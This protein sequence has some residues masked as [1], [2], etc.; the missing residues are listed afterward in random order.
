MPPFGERG[1]AETGP[2]G[3]P[4]HWKPAGPQAEWKTIPALPIRPP[5]QS[6]SALP[7]LR[8]SGAA[9]LYQSGPPLRATVPQPAVDALCAEQPADEEIRSDL[10]ECRSEQSDR[11]R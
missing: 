5:E 10:P 6:R 8:R 7:L 2:Q 4:R 3:P 1:Q 11:R 9:L